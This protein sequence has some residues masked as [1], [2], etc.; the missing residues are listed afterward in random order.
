[1]TTPSVIDRTR[2][3]EIAKA[4][5]REEILAAARRVFA[6]RGFRGTTI[7]DIAEDAGIALGTIYLYFASK[8]EVFAALNEQFNALIVAAMIDV[9]EGVSL[10]DTIR[11]RVDNVFNT[12]AAN[13]DLVRLVVLNTDPDSAATKRMRDADVERNGPMVDAIRQAMLAGYIRDSDPSVM[14]RLINGL[15]SIAVYQV[16]VLS[17]GSEAGPYREACG[18]MILSYMTPP[19]ANGASGTRTHIQR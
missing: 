9:P 4:A 2:R 14:T 5:R 7:A 13:R 8:D 3:A 19:H 18:D 11:R 12:C 15:V 16:F 6:A 1:M 17:D 10:E